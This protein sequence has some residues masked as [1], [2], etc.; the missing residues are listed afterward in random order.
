MMEM[1]MEVESRKDQIERAAE[2]FNRAH[3]KVWDL[4]VKFTRELHTRGFRNSSA[5]GVFERIRWETDQADMWG[6]SEFKINNNYSAYYARWY[7]S[8]FPD[9]KGFYRTRRRISA[10]VRAVDADVLTPEDFFD[11]AEWS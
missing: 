6:M 5:K 11:D 8:A 7:M 4:F 9:Y 2:D 10:S 3:P 1:E